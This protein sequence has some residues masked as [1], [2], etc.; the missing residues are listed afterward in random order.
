M[1][2]I[3]TLALLAAT[4]APLAIPA[5]ANA[6]SRGEVRDSYRD[7]QEEQRELRE[8]QRHGDRGDI[9][10]ERRDV[11][12]ARREHREDWRDYREHNRRAYA[13]GHWRA[14]FRYQRWHSGVVLRPHYYAPRYYINDYGRYRLPQPGRGLRW[15]RHYDDV[16]L[17]NIRNGRIVQIYYS[18]FW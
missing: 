6:Q 13:R 15:V 17:V 3:L 1:R 5:A 18:F 4:V 14:P 7:L 2:K 9:R 10:E 12:E 11:R 16:L 8:A